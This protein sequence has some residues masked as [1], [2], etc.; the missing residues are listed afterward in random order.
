MFP[1]PVSFPEEAL[2]I[3]LPSPLPLSRGERVLIVLSRA[4]GEGVFE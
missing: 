3:V 2:V 4:R 1:P